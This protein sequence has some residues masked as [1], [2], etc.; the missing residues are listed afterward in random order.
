[1][2]ETLGLIPSSPY[3]G[4]G[5]HA[6]HPSTW[7]GRQEDQRFRAILNYVDLS[8]LRPCFPKLKSS[9]VPSVVSA[10]RSVFRVLAKN[11]ESLRGPRKVICCCFIPSKG[12][13]G[14][15]KPQQADSILQSIV[16]F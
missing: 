2:S 5:G 15:S 14:G 13:E 7:R 3:I 11:S 4:H 9:C 1:M 12:K 16:C 10:Q 6:R 8:F